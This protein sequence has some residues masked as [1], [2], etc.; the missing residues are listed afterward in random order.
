[1]QDQPGAA[2]VVPAGQQPLEEVQVL[3]GGGFVQPELF[4]DLGDLRRVAAFSAGEAGRVA[5]GEVEEG[6]DDDGQGEQHEQ[7][8]AGPFEHEA[9]HAVRSFLVPTRR[10]EPS[11]GSRAVRTASPSTV[12]AS[13]VTKSSPAGSRT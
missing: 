1:M 9:G 4:A 7:C 10:R 3:G 5:G 13:T 12:E 6:V 8:A 11:R 2:G